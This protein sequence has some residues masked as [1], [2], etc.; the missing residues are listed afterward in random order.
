MQTTHILL[1]SCC[2]R[3][4]LLGGVTWVLTPGWL[5]PTQLDFQNR[6]T[7]G[8][9]NEL[10]TQVTQ[11]TKPTIIKTSLQ[12]K[13]QFIFDDI[14]WLWLVCY[15][16]DACHHRANLIVTTNVGPTNSWRREWVWIRHIR[17][18]VENIRVW[19]RN[20]WVWIR[21]IRVWAVNIS[22][23]FI[24]FACVF[25]RIC[26]RNIR[27]WIRNI[28]VWIKNI[29]VWIRN[30]RVWIRNLRVWAVNMSLDVHGL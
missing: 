5:P 2:S 30:I 13:R 6:R 23:D 24:H 16:F 14:L 12:H 18:W 20:I 25:L 1:T 22:M 8:D 3:S 21:N 4:K 9:E 26:I 10:T 27:V 28:L 17:V 11:I 29:R 7:T 19:I 15:L